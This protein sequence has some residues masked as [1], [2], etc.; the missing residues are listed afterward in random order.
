MDFIGKKT[1]SFKSIETRHAE[2][3]EAV[4]RGLRGLDR[5]GFLKVSAA[6]AGAVAAQGLC[7]PHSFQPVSVAFAAPPRAPAAGSGPVA[8]KV[9]P[10]RFAY[11]SDSHL[12]PK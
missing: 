4:F 9:K 10:F 6:A 12:Y 1:S 7:S 11:I 8:S 2:E 3:R 5:R